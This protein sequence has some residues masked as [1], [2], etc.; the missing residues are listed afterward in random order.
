M[1]QLNVKKAI[2]YSDSHRKFYIEQPSKYVAQGE[3]TV[4]N[5]RKSFID[6]SKVLVFSLRSN[7]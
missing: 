2:F 7:L 4:A 3:N 5:S 1:F 6:L